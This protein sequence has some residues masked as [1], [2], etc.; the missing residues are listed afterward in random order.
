M[1]TILVPK[2]FFLKKKV[3]F[4]FSEKDIL[5]AENVNQLKG[6]NKDNSQAYL[7]DITTLA[8]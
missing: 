8:A 7:L 6:E 4:L 3:D 1:V 5:K 2:T